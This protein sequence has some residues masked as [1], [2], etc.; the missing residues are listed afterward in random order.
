MCV[1]VSVHLQAAHFSAHGLLRGVAGL[2]QAAALTGTFIMH[3]ITGDMGES[4][5]LC[6]HCNPSVT[7]S[8]RHT[9]TLSGG[10]IA[11]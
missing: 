1:C 9:N 4:A 11:C 2:L 5:V 6:V 7:Q 10:Q 3:K 8:L